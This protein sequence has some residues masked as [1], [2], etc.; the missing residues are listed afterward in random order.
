LSLDLLPDE[1]A[2]FKETRKL[3]LSW[4]H[5][6]LTQGNAALAEIRQINERLTRLK[7]QIA[8]AFPLDDQEVRSFMENVRS[9][10][11]RI[12]DVEAA[13]IRHLQQAMQ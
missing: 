10:V 7:Q 9:H 1:M 2:P 13:A 5:L 8:Q 11:L 4:H 12:H 3:I 6:F